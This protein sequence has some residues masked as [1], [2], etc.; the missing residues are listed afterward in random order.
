MKS[1]DGFEKRL[2]RLSVGHHEALNPLVEA[3]MA[4]LSPMEISTVASVLTRSDNGRAP[5]EEELEFIA[6]LC[7]RPFQPLPPVDHSAPRCNICGLQPAREHDEML[8]MCD[9]CYDAASGNIEL[10]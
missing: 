4:V 9:R 8:P 6:N 1:I 5:T 2:I 7:K 10:V 3:W